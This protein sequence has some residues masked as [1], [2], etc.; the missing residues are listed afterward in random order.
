MTGEPYDL[1]RDEGIDFPDDPQAEPTS[2]EVKDRIDW[3]ETHPI[4]DNHSG[5]RDGC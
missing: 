1:Q 3:Y 5:I 2:D 4:M